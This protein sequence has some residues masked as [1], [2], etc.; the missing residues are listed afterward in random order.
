MPRVLLNV[1]MLVVALA[2]A[3]GI[4]VANGD[5]YEDGAA[6]LRAK[7]YPRARLIWSALALQGD[8]RAQYSLG[9][10][11]EK[12]QGVDRDFEE[13]LRWYR[14]SADQGHADSQYRVAVAYSFGLGG[15]IKDDATAAKWLHRAAENG[16]RKSQRLLA[17]AYESG[18]L[19]I[20]PDEKKAKH[21]KTLAEGKKR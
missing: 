21:W 20:T 18:E 11:Y 2:T 13:A 15:V 14:K 4:V 5:S 9:R 12:A 7:D 3:P 16:H 17:R 1:L 19:G 8:P 10:M 6:A